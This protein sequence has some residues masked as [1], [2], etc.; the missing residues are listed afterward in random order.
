LGSLFDRMPFLN[1]SNSAG[2]FMSD[3][4]LSYS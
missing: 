2:D 1:S 3:M 4:I